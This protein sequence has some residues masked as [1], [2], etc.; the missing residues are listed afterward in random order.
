MAQAIELLIRAKNDSDAAFRAY[1]KNLENSTDAAKKASVSMDSVTVRAGK[2]SDAIGRTSTTLARSADAFGLSAGAMRTIGDV[3]DVAQLGFDNLSKSAVGFNA[4]SLAVVG[5]G[6]AIG[7]AIGKMAM[8]FDV[9]RNAAF[10]AGEAIHNA[11][12]S[13]QT[14]GVEEMAQ[15]TANW[16][17]EQK[18]VAAANEAMLRRV[19]S[20][21]SVEEIKQIL[22]PEPPKG[23]KERILDEAKAFEQA[24]K[25][26]EAAAKQAAAAGAA[27]AKQAAAE[28]LAAEKKALAEEKKL[29][30]DLF[31]AAKKGYA[32]QVAEEKR[33]REAEWEEKKRLYQEEVEAAREA[34]EERAESYED[35]SAAMLD[36]IER[37]RQAELDAQEDFANLLGELAG[38]FESLGGTAGNALA[39]IARGFSEGLHA[40]TAFA[41]A[42]NKAQKAMAILGAAQSAMKGGVLGGATTGAAFGAQFGILGAGIGAAAGALL[43]FFGKAKA[44]R[45]EME[46]LRNEF[47]KS[48]GGMTALKTQA[49]AAGISLDGMFKQKSAAALA[50]QIDTIKAKLQ[51]WDEAQRILKEGMDRYGISVS[52]MGARFAA[53]ELDKQAREMAM[54]FAAAIQV[55]ANATAVTAGMK[56]EVLALVAQYQAAGMAIPAALRPVLEAM[57]QN[58]QLV[59]ENGEAFG[60]LE[61]AGYTFAETMEGALGNLTAEL[62][63]LRQVLAQGFHIPITYDVNGAPG[64]PT[65]STGGAGGSRPPREE[66]PEFAG[67]G[68][69]GGG[70]QPFYAMLHPRESVVPDDK[71]PGFIAQALAMAAPMMGGGNQSIRI[72]LSVGNRELG[73]ATTNITRRRQGTV[74]VGALRRHG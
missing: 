72:G 6:L 69:T 1:T 22:F 53:L 29:R 18:K 59:D 43:G 4:A 3:A 45:E 21:K 31:A 27:A 42:T 26:K 25:Q 14:Q 54:F 16:A 66:V 33:L 30:E 34:D 64:P 51:D 52:D 41:E 71:M 40:A 13:Q 23:I 35:M 17:I 2:L 49:A 55:G 15:A 37:R 65:G 47:V 48:A 60:S 20:G 67:G 56:D 50:H 62:A 19:T 57:R 70:S 7:T 39:S 63:K 46:K 10:A 73:Q 74:N 32:D 36:A 38:I 61:E 9:V 11:F 8:E 68:H 28:R 58:G 44:A 12:S 24:Q 5:A